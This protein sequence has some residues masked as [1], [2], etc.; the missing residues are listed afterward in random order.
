MVDGSVIIIPS[1][2]SVVERIDT[3]QNSSYNIMVIVY[4]QVDIDNVQGKEGQDIEEL[5]LS[6]AELSLR[7]S[8]PFPLPHYIWRKNEEEELNNVAVHSGI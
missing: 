7:S 5:A 1:R 8:D 6:V 2:V 3:Q 4:A